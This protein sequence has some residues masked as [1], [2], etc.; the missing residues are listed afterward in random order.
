MLFSR[1]SWWFD[2]NFFLIKLVV[3]YQGNILE[4]GNAVEPKYLSSFGSQF[5]TPNNYV[6]F[7]EF[8]Q[9]FYGLSNKFFG[10]DLPT[11]QNDINSMKLMNYLQSIPEYQQA[12]REDQFDFEMPIIIL[13]GMCFLDT[14]LMNKLF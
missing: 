7:T 13:E 6:R 9:I 8:C 3:K 5:S 1:F 11:I 4:S 2:L 10:F 14:V 12:T